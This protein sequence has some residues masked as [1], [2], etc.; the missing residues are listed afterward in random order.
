MLIYT[1]KKTVMKIH[2]PITSAEFVVLHA[3]MKQKRG[4]NP[5]LSFAGIKN[6][7][8]AL[9]F[10]KSVASF[11]TKPAAPPPGDKVIILP[12]Q[13]EMFERL[14]AVDDNPHTVREFYPKLLKYAGQRKVAAGIVMMAELALFDYTKGMPDF[15]FSVMNM[16]MPE[17]IDALT[18]N[19]EVATEA[20]KILKEALVATTA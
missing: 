15:M 13:E 6:P 1:K 18:D 17:Y 5:S 19:K 7:K 10:A 12:N 16:R 14:M 11:N 4:R 20:K 9:Q 8:R 2:F 3:Q